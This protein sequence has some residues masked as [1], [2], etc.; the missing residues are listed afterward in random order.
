MH[1]KPPRKYEYDEWAWYLKLIGE[2]EGSAESH[3]RPHIHPR[4]QGKGLGTSVGQKGG[5]DGDQE[6]PKTEKWS[7]VG[8]RSPLMGGKEEAEWVLERLVRTLE[9]ELEAC[10]RDELELKGESESQTVAEAVGGSTAE[11]G[12][13]SGSNKISQGKKGES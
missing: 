2:D 13:S 7:W 10:K 12:E 9:W 6:E 3:R 1:S 11:K 5:R 4:G 8:E